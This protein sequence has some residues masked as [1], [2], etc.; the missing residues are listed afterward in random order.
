[1]KPSELLRQKKTY[2]KSAKAEC[3]DV[4]CVPQAELS[5]TAVDLGYVWSPTRTP[6]QVV[7]WLGD[8]TGDAR[9]ALATLAQ[10]VEQHRYAEPGVHGTSGTDDG[11]DLRDE[12]ARITGRLRAGQ[13][14]ATRLRAALW[15]AS[16]RWL[17]WSGPARHRR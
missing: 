9:G 4:A 10:A 13:D 1:M 6:R 17:R 3:D 15:P 12:L 11:P 2:Q 5:D 7:R 16:L 8:A 14:R